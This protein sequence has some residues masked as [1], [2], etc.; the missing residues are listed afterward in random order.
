MT[1]FLAV[2][3]AILPVA[4]AVPLELDYRLDLP[5]GAARGV[6]IGVTAVNAR[7]DDKGGD[8]LASIGTVRASAGIPYALKTS[9][10]NI[11]A[12]LVAWAADV[13]ESCGFTT[14]KG[15]RDAAN[16]RA[17]V[18]IEYFWID[19]Y[20]AYALDMRLRVEILGPGAE[21]PTL[22]LA[23]HGKRVESVEWGVHELN[24]PINA[25]LEDESVRFREVCEGEGFAAIVRGD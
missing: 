1:L 23:L 21:T 2:L 9:D 5:D 11:D 24:K 3:T 16:G 8:E 4:R 7:P 25:V 6:T 14:R 17:R 20:M 13:L 10:G 19:G 22:T 15:S 12:F 18:M